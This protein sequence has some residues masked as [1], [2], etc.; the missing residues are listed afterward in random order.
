MRWSPDPEVIAAAQKMSAE[1]LPA[2]EAF[3]AAASSLGR[4]MA[5]WAERVRPAF[6]ALAS[7]LSR[8]E[9]RAAIERAQ[10]AP[11]RQP[12]WCLCGAAH[13][14]EQGICDGQGTIRQVE[15]P[16]LGPVYVAYCGPC[17]AAM[18]AG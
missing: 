3:A 1:G 7:A 6:E 10:A 8:P 14:G 9:V 16:G 11:R 18:D 15:S 2:A 12:C 13:P 17:A 4:A 5:E